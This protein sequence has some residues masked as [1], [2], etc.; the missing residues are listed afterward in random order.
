[1]NTPSHMDFGRE[2]EHILNMYNG[3]LLLVDSV[4]GLKP[5]TCF[6]LEKVF[7]KGMKV[8]LMAWNITFHINYINIFNYIK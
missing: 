6:V 5:Q 7:R 8:L 4:Q 3:V 2:V 1:M